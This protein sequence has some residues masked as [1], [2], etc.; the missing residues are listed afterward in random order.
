MHVIKSIKQS[1]HPNTELESMM[2][3]FKEM[4]NH[5]IRL[6]L[7]NNISTLKKFSSMFYHD[8]DIYQIQSKYKL[9]A[10][11]HAC[12]RLSQMKASIKKGK[13]VKSPFVRKPFLVSCYGFKINGMLL[14]IPT[15]NRNYVNVVL[16]D[17][18]T[19]KLSENCIKPRSFTITPDLLSICI[20]KEVQE[21]IPQSVIGIDRNL[22]N[23]TISTPTDSIMYKRQVIVNQGK[24][25]VCTSVF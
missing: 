4:I 16:N 25:A 17:Y 10:M 8:L 5:C 2:D 9:T 6:G 7:D 12:G 23:V 18:I 19:K 14:S 11:S 15:G 22:R 24:L 3:T 20:R 13:T 1:F 21:I